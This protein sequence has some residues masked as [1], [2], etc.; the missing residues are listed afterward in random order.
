MTTTIHTRQRVENEHLD[1]QIDQIFDKAPS[2]DTPHS[3]PELTRL[4]RWG[5]GGLLITAAV[6]FML[7]GFYSFA[8]ITRHWIML[9]IC[10]LLG[11]LGVVT[12]TVLKEE[13][14]ARA[15]LGFAAATFPVLSS[16]LGAMFFSLFG[17]P[18][19]DMPR[20]LVFSSF[21]TYP[22]VTFITGLT[23]AI[24]VP[25]SYLSFRILAGCQAML[26][27]V[28][29]TLANLCILFP[30]REGMWGGAIVIAVA[31]SI[32]WIDSVWMRGDFRLESFEGRVA[33]LM[34]VGPVVVMIGRTFFYTMGSTFYGLLIG[35]MGAYL[36]FHWGRI[37]RLQRADLRKM[38]QLV[39]LVGIVAGWVISLWPVLD[40]ISF[41]E[42]MT[43]YLIL[44]PI[45]TLLGAQSLVA[46]SCATAAYR[47]AAAILALL[48]V[49]LAHWVEA[50]PMVSIVAVVVAIATATAG[51]L[52]G[53]KPVFIFGLLA[54]AIGLGNFCL[55]AFKLHSDYAWVALALI[56][57]GT[58]FSASIVEK[59]RA[60]LYFQGTSLWGRFKNRSNECGDNTEMS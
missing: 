5:G 59:G 27:T 45:A 19:L 57:I 32:Y 51:T 50:T 49:V 12:A 9:A 25:V 22:M 47:C 1:F 16:Q 7:Q 20:S 35:L 46:D 60:R 4:L 43:V 33:R 40:T 38:C 14:G 6:V 18:P 41:S 3:T 42:G 53:E 17:S 52:A 54:A 24:V 39:G 56:G 21:A 2:G 26:L 34:L 31:G 36:A 48:T 23:L 11:L 8:P 28:V 29:F 44:L 55:H 13:K 30:V 58:M 15:F 10:G 37:G